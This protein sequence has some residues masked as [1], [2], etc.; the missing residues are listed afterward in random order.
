M[1]EA[2]VHFSSQLILHK[3]SIAWFCILHNDECHAQVQAFMR[4]DG[5][6]CIASQDTR[7]ADTPAGSGTTALT[8]LVW[9]SQL[10][11]ANAGDCRAVLCRRG[12]AIDLTQD[13]R[14]DNLEEALRVR[15]AGGHICPDGYLNGHLAVL[16]ALGDHHYRDLK[17]PSGPNGSMH[18]PLIARPEV[19][20]H[21]ILPEDEFVL[22]A[23]DGMW[24]VLPSQTAVSLARQNLR[25]HNDPERCSQQLVSLSLLL[26]SSC[27]MLAKLSSQYTS[28]VHLAVLCCGVLHALCDRN[29]VLPSTTSRHAC[30]LRPYQ[31]LTHNWMSVQVNESLKLHTSDNVSVI[32]VCLT[33]HAPPARTFSGRLSVQRSISQDGLS[34]IGSA[35]MDVNESRIGP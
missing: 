32:T 1:Q 35:L 10:L 22:I 30:T 13:H 17:S 24:D 18:G 21:D 27:L 6:L 4:T 23:C 7:S 25:E 16:R 28:H 31:Q 26:Q 5:E 15:A 29:L 11:L 20:L 9:G 19:G 3:K 2:M 14:P 12:K 33:E 8:A 34:R